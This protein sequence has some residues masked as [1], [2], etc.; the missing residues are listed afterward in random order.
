M[1]LHILRVLTYL[2]ASGEEKRLQEADLAILTGPVVI[3]GDPGM[4]KTTLL[5]TLGDVAGFRYVTARK[6]IRVPDPGA[7]FS[8]DEV[9]VIDALDEVASARDTDAIN[10]V[11][12]QLVRAGAPRFILSCR[13][14]EWQGAVGRQD[15]REEYQQD[16]WVLTLSPVSRDDAIDCPFAQAIAEVANGGKHRTLDDKNLVA[17]R[18]VVEFRLCGYGEG[19]YGVGPFGQANIQL[20]GRRAKSEAP[21][22]HSIS[23]VLSEAATWWERRL[24][25]NNATAGDE[26]PEPKPNIQD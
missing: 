16:P 17:D 1:P 12:T 19:G 11:L 24:G 23:V 6:F 13:G 4:G 3:L 2:D 8:S 7:V 5:E 25:S 15:I 18:D 22:W 26:T 14:A 9:V 20:H 21:T 10:Q